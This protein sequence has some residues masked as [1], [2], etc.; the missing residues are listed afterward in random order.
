MH[1]LI[2]LR[3]SLQPETAVAELQNKTH[4]RYN[5]TENKTVIAD[6]ISNA[7]KQFKTINTLKLKKKS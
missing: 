1:L 7:P 3:N 4:N 5:Y 2:L 6:K